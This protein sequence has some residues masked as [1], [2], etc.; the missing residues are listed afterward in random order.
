[1]MFSKL[2]RWMGISKAANNNFD[3]RC[4]LVVDDSAVDLTLLRK[5]IEKMGHRVLSA[6]NGQIGYTLAKLERPDLIFSDWRMPTLDGIGMCK[7]LKADEETK[8]IPVVFLTS[9]DTPKAVIDGFEIGA[10]N[11]LVKPIKPKLLVSK[12]NS[13]FKECLAV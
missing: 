3:R 4:V 11:Y 10:Y 12:I 9:V 1:M 13:I 5:T 8:N 2:A 6:E 7:Q